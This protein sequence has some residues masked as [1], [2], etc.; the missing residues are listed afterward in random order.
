M[1]AQGKEEKGRSIQASIKVVLV[2]QFGHWRRV[3]LRSNAREIL[4]TRVNTTDKM[5]AAGFA[6]NQKQNTTYGQVLNTNPVLGSNKN[7]PL[8]P[9]NMNPTRRISHS[10][11]R[12]PT[13]PRQQQQLQRVVELKV[14]LCCQGCEENV[15]FELTSLDGVNEI[16]VDMETQKVVVKGE[17]QPSTILKTVKRVENRAEFWRN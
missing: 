2:L 10:N 6:Y 5:A 8:P 15:R 7:Q 12:P 1:W 16:S 13:F 4:R 17:I 3:F 11:A 14:P 9:G